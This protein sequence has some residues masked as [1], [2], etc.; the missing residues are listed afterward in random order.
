[1]RI[2]RHGCGSKGSGRRRA[3]LLRRTHDTAELKGDPMTKTLLSSVFLSLLCLVAACAGPRI[4]VPAPSSQMKETETA[5]NFKGVHIE[6]TGEGWDQ[7]TGV[8]N[9]I[10]P[11]GITISNE[12]GSPLRISYTIFSLVDG[13]GNRYSVLPPYSLEDE[14]NEADSS[15]FTCSGFYVAPYYSRYYPLLRMYDDPFYYDPLYFQHYYSCWENYDPGLPTKEMI[16]K[17]FPE[18][19]LW[20]RVT[21]SGFLYFEKVRKSDSYMFK[22]ELIDTATGER[23]GGIEIPLTLKK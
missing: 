17:A 4:L 9:E 12:S 5:N 7:D 22:V 14:N 16:D 15:N 11:L 21:T 3:C 20:D 8:Y 2:V 13:E 19:V 1:M 6:V 10:T 18:G 23:L